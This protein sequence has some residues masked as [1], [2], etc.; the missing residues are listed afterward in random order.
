METINEIIKQV[1][2]QGNI[3]KVAITKD[4]DVLSFIIDVE[5]NKTKPYQ[6][7]SN[8]I[9]FPNDFVILR[10]HTFAETNALAGFII[11][12]NNRL[13]PS[14][15]YFLDASNAIK[16]YPLDSTY[17]TGFYC[18]NILIVKH[19]VEIEIPKDSNLIFY[20]YNAHTS[21]QEIYIEMKGYHI[22]K[23]IIN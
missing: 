10:F 7:N 17:A 13:Y 9:K 23:R 2:L 22:F 5:A 11:G 4:F 1:D 12:I 21:D 15:F 3:H 20:V 14:R 16:T 18:S 19:E 6:L 8:E